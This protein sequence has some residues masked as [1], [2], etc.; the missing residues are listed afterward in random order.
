[1][2]LQD[3]ISNDIKDAMRAKDADKL[4]V[5][6]MLNAAIKNKIISLRN[7]ELVVLT[8]EQVK[9]VIASEVKKRQDSAIE[10]EKGGRPE[11]AAKETAEVSMLVGY[12][13]TPMSDDESATGIKEVLDGAEKQDFGLIMKEVMA[14]FKGKVDGR[15]A[16]EMIKKLMQK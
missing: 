11:L 15:R 5:L 9:E 1:M 12:L 7:G 8:D 6:R 10:Y 14:K 4:S 2:S 3:Q 16:G 13:P